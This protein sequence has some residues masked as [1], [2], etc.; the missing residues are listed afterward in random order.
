MKRNIIPLKYNC[1]FDHQANPVP[2]VHINANKALWKLMGIDPVC[3]RNILKPDNFGPTV[4]LVI[5]YYVGIYFRAA[6]CTRL[7][8]VIAEI[9]LEKYCLKRNHE[10]RKF[11]KS[12]E[13]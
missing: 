8:K 13:S 5:A 11:Q 10:A 2:L 12:R 9:K 4:L 6:V 3:Y 7:N 1:I